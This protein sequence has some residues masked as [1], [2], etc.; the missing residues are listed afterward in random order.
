M[1]RLDLECRSALLP[2]GIRSLIDVKVTT[3]FG[4]FDS[5]GEDNIVSLIGCLP[6]LSRL[7]INIWRLITFRDETC[8]GVINSIRLEERLDRLEAI[9]MAVQLKLP[10]LKY[11]IAFYTCDPGFISA[12]AADHLQMI[13]IFQS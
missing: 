9:C 7:Q 3:H 2:F 11:T 5:S 10:G 12:S 8:A 4:L 13:I 6:V 1:T